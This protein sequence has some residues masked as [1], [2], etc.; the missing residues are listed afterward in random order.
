M[1]T[2]Y[3]K[4]IPEY[5]ALHDNLVPPSSTLYATILPQLKSTFNKIGATHA[6]ASP[7]PEKKAPNEVAT[8]LN[9]L[10]RFVFADNTMPNAMDNSRKPDLGCGPKDQII[11]FMTATHQ[12]LVRFV[13][14]VSFAAHLTDSMPVEIFAEHTAPQKLVQHK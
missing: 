4:H 5:Q 13:V 3:D 9:V 12:A 10:K 11:C 2:V 7:I 8:Q 14:E 1:E 6:S